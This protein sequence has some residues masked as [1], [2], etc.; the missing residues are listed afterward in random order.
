MISNRE[1]MFS[2][3]EPEAIYTGPSDNEVAIR[4]LERLAMRIAEGEVRVEN[5]TTKQAPV[6]MNGFGGVRVMGTKKLEVEFYED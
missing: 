6:Q 3:D 2:E 1:K 4:E 5:V